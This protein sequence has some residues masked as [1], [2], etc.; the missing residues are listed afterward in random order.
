MADYTTVEEFNAFMDL[1]Y[2]SGYDRLEFE[3]VEYLEDYCTAFPNLAQ[4]AILDTETKN[5]ITKAIYYQIEYINNNPSTFKT[6][7]NSNTTS[8]SVGKFSISQGTSKD[9][10]ALNDVICD[11]SKQLMLKTG[12]CHKTTNF[13]GCDCQCN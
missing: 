7:S 6:G 1:N 2:S 3:A 13:K 9:N 5:N 10:E 8:F 4:W 12:I 11:K